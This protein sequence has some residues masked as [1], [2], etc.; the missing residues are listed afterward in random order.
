MSKRRRGFLDALVSFLVF[1]VLVAFVVTCCFFLFLNIMTEE[2]NL[3][4]TN[5]HLQMAAKLTFANVILLSFVFSVA[6]SI[7]RHFTVQ[8]P[9]QK[10]L[11]ATNA[12]ANGDFSVRLPELSKLDIM[13][14]FGDIGRNLNHM[15]QELSG[16]ETLRTDFIANVSHELKTP[17][18]VIQ[19]YGTMLQQPGLEEETRIEYAKTISQTSRRL[20]S[21]ITN[22]LKLNKLETSRSSRWWKNTTWASRFVSACWDS[23]MPGRKRNWRLTPTSK[24]A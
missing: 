2:M 11:D 23:K 4:L 19:N 13:Y 17:L 15:A 24:K 16:T 10:I 8:R 22:I 9:V 12:M 18:A 6:D 20:A 14:G 1:F 5:E 3:E 21:L 7:R